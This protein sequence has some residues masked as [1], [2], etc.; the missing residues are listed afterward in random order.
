MDQRLPPS[1]RPLLDDYLARLR[2]DLPDLLDGLYVYGSVAL[3]AFDERASDVDLLALTRRRCT[4]ADLAALGALHRDVAARWPRPA[5]EVSYVAREDRGLRGAAAP[6]HPFHHDGVLHATDAGDPNSPFRSAIGWWQV[7]RHGIA[8][9]GPPPTELGIQ[10]TGADLVAD[11]RALVD[12]HWRA[13][14]R[15]PRL[16][17]ALRHAK[18]VEWAVL[19]ILRTWYT[20][21][22]R[23]VPTKA[24]AADYALAR[25]PAGWHRLIRETLAARGRMRRPGLRTALDAARFMRFMVAEC[26]RLAPAGR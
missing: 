23:D 1:L 6:A 11:S 3:G 24:A 25:L 9:A 5:L 26:D 19:G 16:V 21:N 14:T 20:L 7:A 17:L 2:R 22:E 10:V 15:S 13:W 4:T 12:A 18:S 8:L